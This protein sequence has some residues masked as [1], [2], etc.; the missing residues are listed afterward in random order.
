M[1]L[2]TAAS[3]RVLELE[4]ILAHDRRVASAGSESQTDPAALHLAETPTERIRRFTHA[5]GT[6]GLDADNDAID[7]LTM[8]LLLNDF[9]RAVEHL[10]AVANIAAADIDRAAKP[11]RDT[12]R[13]IEVENGRVEKLRAQSRA[14]DASD[15]QAS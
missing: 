2:P 13:L 7:I 6:A 8:R 1:S 15:S 3:E 4:R 10:R 14:R 9:S 11:V 12:Q 5:L